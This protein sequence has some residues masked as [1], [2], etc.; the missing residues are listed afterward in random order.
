MVPAPV[1][2]FPF[3]VR[4]THSTLR[5]VARSISAPANFTGER[6]RKSSKPNVTR[7]LRISV[8]LRPVDTVADRPR[9]TTNHDAAATPACLRKVLL[10]GLDVAE[11]ENGMR[12][13]RVDFK[14][15]RMIGRCSFRRAIVMKPA[16]ANV[17][18][19]PVKRFGGTLRLLSFD[20][21]SPEL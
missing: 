20:R 14:S 6:Y 9:F 18:A 5:I 4:T 17:E 11:V 8:G 1:A 2:T 10:V 3:L 15:W 16:R 19:A 7:S 21:I 12:E 13:R